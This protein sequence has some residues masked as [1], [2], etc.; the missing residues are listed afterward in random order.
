VSYRFSETEYLFNSDLCAPMKVVITSA[1]E[2]EI[3]STTRDLSKVYIDQNI[4]ELTFHQSGVGMLSSA[5]SLTQMIENHKPDLVIQAGIG[6]CFSETFNLG[7]VVTVKEEHLADMG[8]EEGTGWMD[9]FD[10]N[11]EYANRLPF[12]NKKLTNTHLEKLNLLRLPQVTAIT[13]NEITT[14][15][16]R[17]E[18]LAAKYHPVIESMEG[19]SLHYVCRDF[20]VLFIQIRAIS[21]YIGERNKSNWKLKEAIKNL[22]DVLA[23]YIHQLH[24]NLKNVLQ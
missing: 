19:A 10:L 12:E 4:L 11:L 20:G 5:V 22:N 2:G 7:E 24:S 8:V 9:I 13:I 15:K 1:T 21:N 16:Q 3:V 17:V 6:G 18:Q 23:S 14:R